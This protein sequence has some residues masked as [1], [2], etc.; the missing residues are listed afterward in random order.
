[1]NELSVQNGSLDGINLIKVV[2]NSGCL[3]GSSVHDLSIM[4]PGY[5]SVIQQTPLPTAVG[6][7]RKVL[8]EYWTFENLHT[9]TRPDI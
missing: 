4:R 1:M 8:L 5:E 7:K 6:K 2:N 9:L 3:I